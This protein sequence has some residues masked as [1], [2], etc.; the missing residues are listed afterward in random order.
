[1]LLAGPL[2]LCCSLD[3]RGSGVRASAAAQGAP[4]QPWQA[5][6]LYLAMASLGATL[7]AYLAGTLNLWLTGV[8][9]VGRSI[10]GALVG[11]ILGTLSIILFVVLWIVLGKIGAAQMLR[12]FLSLCVPPAI[13]AALFGAYILYAR[14]RL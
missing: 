10:E 2:L 9:G 12:L 3:A 6:P 7:G 11:A 4:R 1:M 5:H 13:V 8:D 14:S